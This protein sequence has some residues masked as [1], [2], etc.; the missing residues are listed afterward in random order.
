MVMARHLDELPGRCL[1]N[2]LPFSGSRWVDM[3]EYLDTFEMSFEEITP[4]GWKPFAND[5][6]TASW[7]LLVGL[8]PR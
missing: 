1:P 6:W 3:T 8:T 4:S 7:L 5:I 2:L